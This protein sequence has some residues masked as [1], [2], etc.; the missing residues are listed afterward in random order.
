MEE[1]FMRLWWIPSCMRFTWPAGI[2]VT[3]LNHFRHLSTFNLCHQPVLL[4]NLQGGHSRQLLFLRMNPSLQE[5]LACVC[6]IQNSKQLGTQLVIQTICFF[7]LSCDEMLIS[8]SEDKL[9]GQRNVPIISSRDTCHY[10]TSCTVKLEHCFCR[11]NK[12]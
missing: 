10:T 8:V 5:T 9:L 12:K 1:C 3:M 6:K 4:T 11:C 7:Y 2:N